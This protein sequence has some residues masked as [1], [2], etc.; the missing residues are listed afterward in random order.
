MTVTP[1]FDGRVQVDCIPSGSMRSLIVRDAMQR[2]IPEYQEWAAD[3]APRSLFFNLS[4][5]L[6]CTKSVTFADDEA[7]PMLQDWRAFWEL[8]RR[9]TDYRALWEAYISLDIDVNNEWAKALD[10]ADDARLKA[11]PFVQPGAPS[12]AELLADGDEG[13]K[14]SRK[15]TPTSTTSTGALETLSEAAREAAPSS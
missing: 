10:A 14:K 12:D 5:C 7:D 9:S 2:A 13:K 15:G 1:V 8:S 11:P 3:S 4:Q 6:A